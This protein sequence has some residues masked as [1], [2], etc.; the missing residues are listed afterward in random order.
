MHS[1][2]SVATAL[3]FTAKFY[4][5][6]NMPVQFSQALGRHR[7]I[8]SEFSSNLF[9]GSIVIKFIIP[10]EIA[11]SLIRVSHWQPSFLFRVSGWKHL[12]TLRH[13]TQMYQAAL[14]FGTTIR[15]C[16]KKNTAHKNTF[17]PIPLGNIHIVGVN[18]RYVRST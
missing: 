17:F 11:Q 1:S 16:V 8:P 5:Y 10:L 6:E 7:K 14:V 4:S 3:F 18:D 2:V 12:I 9:S 13:A 15:T